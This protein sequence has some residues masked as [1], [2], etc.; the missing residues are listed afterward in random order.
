[1]IENPEGVY[2]LRYEGREGIDQGKYQE[3]KGKYFYTL[4]LARHRVM[5]QDWLENLKKRADIEIIER[6]DQEGSGA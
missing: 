6:M 4:M 2:V 3:E 5:L 1:V